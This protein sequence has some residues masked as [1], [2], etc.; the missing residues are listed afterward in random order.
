MLYRL[1]SEDPVLAI[2]TPIGQ[3][4]ESEEEDPPIDPLDDLE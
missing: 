4:V 1:S 2:E 3:D